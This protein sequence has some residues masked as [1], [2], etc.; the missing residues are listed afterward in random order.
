MDKLKSNVKRKEEKEKK[1]ERKIKTKT[2]EKCHY[3]REYVRDGYSKQ[4][5]I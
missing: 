2:M 3:N 4:R 5:Q 1:K